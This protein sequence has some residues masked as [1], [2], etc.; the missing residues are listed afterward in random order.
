[1]AMK[2]WI[3]GVLLIF[4]GMLGYAQTT[5]G[6]DFSELKPE[7]QELLRKTV[8]MVDN[9]MCEAVAPDFDY[10]VKEYPEN[11]LVH[12]ERMY[13]L[14]SLSR[15]DEVVKEA[16]FILNHK[17]TSE[18]AFQMIG[19]AYDYLGK[20][21]EA[22]K[23]YN[24]GLERFPNSGSLYLELGML[25]NLDGELLEALDYYN[26]GILVQ[27]N[28]AS[29]YYRAAPIYFMSEN[30]K[31]WG[32][33]YAE[34]AILL[35]PSNETRHAEMAQ[36]IV[37]NLKECIKPEGKDKRLSAELVPERKVIINEKQEAFMELPGVYEGAM[38]GALKELS[39]GDTP[40]TCSIEQLI[41]IRKGLVENYF[42]V[43]ND[44]YGNSMYLFE[45]YKNLIDAGHWDAYNYFLF[46]STAP[47][48]YA[49]W[50]DTHEEDM[51]AFIDW[52]NRTPFS[53]GDGRSVDPMQLFNSYRTLNMLEWLQIQA[54]LLNED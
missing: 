53:L 6:D 54:G 2:Q 10:L 34:T 22:E 9:G 15:F 14:Y 7:D 5:S 23:I 16:D 47:E 38:D 20:R 29:N 11:Y 27:P 39:L 4:C 30:A 24:E 49:A 50:Y 45:F 28:F 37:Y 41:K 35:A 33:V 26:K 48:E 46:E 3:F 31:V 52:Y 25:S 51:T 44:L 36:L 40:F 18:A 21:K 43:T 12:Y 13:N 8:E 17:Y 42:S 19:N 1:M 32:L